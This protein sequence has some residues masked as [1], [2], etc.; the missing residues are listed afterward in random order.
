[1]RGPTAREGRIGFAGHRNDPHRPL[2][3]LGHLV[4]E[5]VHHQTGIGPAH[6]Q[7]RTATRHLA[8]LLEEHL[9]RGVG[10]IVVIGKL[11]AARQLSLHLGAAQPAAHSHD[12]ALPLEADH[13]GG[14]YGILQVSEFL[15]DH[16][17]LLITQLLGEHLL[18]GGGGHAAELLFLRCHIE[19]H[20][21]SDLGIIRDLAHLF[22]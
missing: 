22:D 7:L 1:M 4:L 11:V 12:H 2:L 6:E 3:D 19:H 8:H 18:G 20:G 13:A 15:L 14:E 16:A 9:E 17:P 5:Q 21:V 10:T